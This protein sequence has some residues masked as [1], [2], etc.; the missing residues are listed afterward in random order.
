VKRAE[1]EGADTEMQRQRRGDVGLQRPGEAE[2][3]RTETGKF[4]NVEI[5]FI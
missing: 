5:L 3:K 1:T 4:L 2:M